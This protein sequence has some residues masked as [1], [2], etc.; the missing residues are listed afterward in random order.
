MFVMPDTSNRYTALWKALAGELEGITAEELTAQWSGRPDLPT[1]R[2]EWRRAIESWTTA[3]DG[4]LRRWLKSRRENSD[5]LQILAN[6][7]PFAEYMPVRDFFALVTSYSLFRLQPYR[8]TIVWD[9]HYNKV[10]PAS[11]IEKFVLQ[12]TSDLTAG[13]TAFAVFASECDDYA[14]GLVVGDGFCNLRGT[15]S[16]VDRLLGIRNNAFV[17]IRSTSV[18]DGRRALLALLVV[19]LPVPNVF[20]PAICQRFSD[21]LRKYEEIFEFLLD[22]EQREEVAALQRRHPAWPG[23]SGALLDLFVDRPAPPDQHPGEEKPRNRDGP[24]DCPAL[25]ACAIVTCQNAP[26]RLEVSV[27]ESAIQF[28][29][30]YE[31]QFCL[32]ASELASYGVRASEVLDNKIILCDAASHGLCL[33]SAGKL[34]EDVPEY[35]DELLGDIS[36]IAVNSSEGFEG[37]TSSLASQ[38]HLELELLR[39]LARGLLSYVATGDVSGRNELANHLQILGSDEQQVSR[40]LKYAENLRQWARERS[41]VLE[42]LLLTVQRPL[43]VFASPLAPQNYLVNI[44]YRRGAAS[45]VPFFVLDPEDPALPGW[46]R[47]AFLEVLEPH[48]LV[49]LCRALLFLIESL[50]QSGSHEFE[51]KDGFLLQKAGSDYGAPSLVLS[52]LLLP[53]GATFGVERD[54]RTVKAKITRDGATIVLTWTLINGPLPLAIAILNQ[55]R[56]RTRLNAT[57]T[58]EWSARGYLFCDLARISAEAEAIMPSAWSYNGIAAQRNAAE[59]LHAVA[60][61][62]PQFVRA[63]DSVA[64]VPLPSPLDSEPP[65]L[66]SWAGVAGEQRLLLAAALQRPRASLP[67]IGPEEKWSDLRDAGT[68]LVV[69][70]FD[71]ESPP[72]PLARRFCDLIR[73]IHHLELERQLRQRDRLDQEMKSRRQHDLDPAI[74]EM[75]AALAD[76]RQEKHSLPR[77]LEL[78]CSGLLSRYRRAG[79]LRLGPQTPSF[80]FDDLRAHVDHSID[81]ARV[82]AWEK[83]QERKLPIEAEKLIGALSFIGLGGQNESGDDRVILLMGNLLANAGVAAAKYGSEV[84]IEFEDNLVRIKNRALRS[85]WEP[86]AAFFNGVAVEGLPGQEGLTDIKRLVKILGMVIEAA[87]EVDADDQSCVAVI[88]L[89]PEYEG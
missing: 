79:R 77:R 7:P 25:P 35:V 33:F 6:L 76:L 83:I 3:A 22:V 63:V 24:A 12:Q 2:A 53:T 40:L 75:E 4:P 56:S 54:G 73:T 65:T 50:P 44:E 80:T 45:P 39:V 78:A 11:F 88:R 21:V 10:V 34:P 47:L 20:S 81:E 43:P 48:S 71:D 74:K 85:D 31:A 59:V 42:Y 87:T 58:G 52:S 72:D 67:A 86:A 64:I 27:V 84:K 1:R 70:C 68:S 57:I 55:P 8:R 51:V 15:Y 17:P 60:E 26:G 36:A 14:Q 32:T 37:K 29:A 5:V 46:V 28:S 66:Q 9:H 49:S 18:V 69:R 61:V 23:D 13:E 19:S 62:S 16:I 41:A 30:G 89:R 38:R 82:R